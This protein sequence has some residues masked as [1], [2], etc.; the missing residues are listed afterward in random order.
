MKKLITAAI[1]FVFIFNKE[2]YSLNTL[3]PQL[4]FAKSNHDIL[5]KLGIKDLDSDTIAGVHIKTWLSEHKLFSHMPPLSMSSYLNREEYD[6]YISDVRRDR[7]LNETKNYILNY[8]IGLYETE[9]NPDYQKLLAW[10]VSLEGAFKETKA[11]ADGEGKT[12]KA[13]FVDYLTGRAGP[14]MPRLGHERSI[15]PLEW[16]AQ[17]RFFWQV[18]E[19]RHGFLFGKIDISGKAIGDLPIIPVDENGRLDEDL[20]QWMFQKES[21]PPFEYYQAKKISLRELLEPQKEHNIKSL[22][23]NF[24]F[25]ETATDL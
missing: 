17:G 22:Q 11:V 1:I 8:A 24:D 13:K 25:G 14:H 7:K 5:I 4:I 20:I 10:V 18:H 16:A 2:A 19:K 3:R 12:F 21:I 9:Q 23:L 15:S 6:K